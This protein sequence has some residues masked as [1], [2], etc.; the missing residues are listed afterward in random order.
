MKNTVFVT[1]A[2]GFIGTQI[3]CHLLQ[4]KEVTVVAL[5]RADSEKGAVQKLARDWLDWP[6][7]V[8]ALETRIEVVRGDVCSARLGLDEAAYLNL[9]SRVT[10][11]IHTAADWRLL[12]LDEL[13][14]TNVQGTANIVAFA[15]EASKHNHLERLSHISTAY[16]AGAATRTI[17]E[18]QLTDR[19]G[20]FTDYERS[21]YEGERL[22]QTAKEELP[23]S[24]FRPS[25]VVGD[26]KTGAIKTFN[27]FYFPLRLYLTGKM[28][29]MPVSR[30]L[31][32]NVVP[33][34]YVAKAVAQLTFEP[35]AE[36][37]TFHVVAPYKSLPKLGELITFVQKWTRTELSCKLP[38]P[39]YLPMSS[40]SMKSVLKL[41]R[42]FTGNRRVSDALISLSPYFS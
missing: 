31:R 28:R 30:S 26:S 10:H 6:E 42:A 24:I 40:S 18:D 29:F 38:S 12:P 3:A 16:V 27:T 37:K 32:I 9:A 33:I 8:G 17:L 7:L 21:K 14:K 39:V 5:V 19:Y 41:Q 15:K 25:M 20:F 23:I 34:D 13:R 22:V 36:G 4:N 35:K 2:S 1:G 11:I